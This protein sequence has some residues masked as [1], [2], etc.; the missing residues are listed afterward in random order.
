MSVRLILPL[1]SQLYAKV[2]PNLQVDEKMFLDSG[3]P[4]SFTK[5]VYR[6]LYMVY[7]TY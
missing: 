6:I 4:A 3:I 7:G 2:L 5:I 1:S